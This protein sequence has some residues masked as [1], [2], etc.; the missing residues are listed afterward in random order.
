MLVNGLIAVSDTS[1]TKWTDKSCCLGDLLVGD[2]I[3][4]ERAFATVES[5]TSNLLCIQTDKPGCV[6]LFH[7]TFGSR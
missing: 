7:L 6:Y 4:G 2:F 1:K 5:P 3:K